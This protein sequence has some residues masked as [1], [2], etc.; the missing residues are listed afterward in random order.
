MT[1]LKDVEKEMENLRTQIED[2]GRL[3]KSI[4]LRSDFTE[5]TVENERL[6]V[7]LEER[8]NRYTK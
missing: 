1:E 8:E 5:R 3:N 4:S 6:N 7:L 2:G